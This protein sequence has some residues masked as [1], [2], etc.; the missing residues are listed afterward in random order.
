MMTA[1]ALGFAGRIASGKST[2]SDRVA[3][4][5]GVPRVSF[6]HYLESV[7]L[8]RGIGEVTREVLRDLGEQEIK[9]HGCSVEILAGR[10]EEHEVVRIRSPARPRLG[11]R[12]LWRGSPSV[13]F[14]SNSGRG[15]SSP[16]RTPRFRSL[17]QAV[18]WRR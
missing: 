10:G 11:A 15:R 12:T 4:R 2:V 16:F 13:G 8:N 9:T 5:L 6:R 17:S 1:P 7:A 18:R 14:G 3:V